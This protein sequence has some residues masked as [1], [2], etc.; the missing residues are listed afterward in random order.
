ME[1][2]VLPLASSAY[3]LLDTYFAWV[4]LSRAGQVLVQVLVHSVS[5][6]TERAEQGLGSSPG[7]C[8][9]SPIPSAARTQAEM[10]AP[11]HLTLHQE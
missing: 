9:L 2:W 8:G 3:S 6:D 1:W 7:T 10:G 4:L 11:P 5:T